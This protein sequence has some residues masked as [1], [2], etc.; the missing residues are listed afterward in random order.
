[1]IITL[2]VMGAL[3]AEEDKSSPQIATMAFWFGGLS[4]LSNA[5]I[6]KFV[7]ND[8]QSI[9]FSAN[10]IAVAILSSC[11]VWLSCKFGKPLELVKYESELSREIK[12]L[13]KAIKQPGISDEAKARLRKKL[14]KA[15]EQYASAES[16]LRSGKMTV[17]TE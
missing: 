16:D 9:C 14:D 7:D 2:K 4:T 1:M 3:M 8:L 11:I 5:C 6:A 15:V 12:K 17:K 10:G 13:E